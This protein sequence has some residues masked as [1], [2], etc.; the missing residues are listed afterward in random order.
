MTVQ[1]SISFGII[2]LQ[3]FEKL[4]GYFNQIYIPILLKFMHIIVMDTENGGNSILVISQF[5]LYLLSSPLAV[6][7]T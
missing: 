1:N 3:H 6:I 5:W 7:Q 4:M 2:L